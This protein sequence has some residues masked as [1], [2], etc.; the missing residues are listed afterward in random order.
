MLPFA[1]TILR[2]L[3]AICRSWSDETFRAGMAV[4]ILLLLSG[5]TF[6]RMVEGWSW[7]DSL[8]FSVMLISTVGLGDLYPVTEFGKIFT[9]F[10]I[11]VGVGVFV[12]LFAQFARALVIGPRKDA[13]PDPDNLKE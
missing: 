11:F 3:K 10:Y 1:L 13:P 6:Y 9:V 5:T 7:L 4:A 12:A 8:Y 2:F